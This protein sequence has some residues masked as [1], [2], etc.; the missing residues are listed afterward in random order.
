VLYQTRQ[1]R[2]GGD[3]ITPA[4]KFLLII[5][6]AVFVLQIFLDPQLLILFGLVP[7]L[8]WQGLYLWQLFTYQFLHG[9]L[10]HLL[11]NM[12]ALW[13]FGCTLERRWGSAFF[14]RYYFVCVV[15]G[16]VLNTVLVPGQNVPSIGASAGIYGILLGFGLIYPDQIVYFYF[17]FPIKMRH[18]V[19]IIGAISLY[20]SIT[21]S[22]GGIAHLAHL[23][24]MLFGYLY[25]R[26]LNPWDRFKLYLDQRRLAR[27]KRR[28]QVIQGRKDDS[29]PTLH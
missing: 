13:M 7:Q 15:G 28:F 19:L 1:I 10:F 20:S 25:L 4:V 29:K 16:A 9:G 8:V 14:L 23:G 11:F 27:L 24:G 12:L 6:T 26:R 22:Q 5:N 3:T 17:L 18:F 21:S 2:F